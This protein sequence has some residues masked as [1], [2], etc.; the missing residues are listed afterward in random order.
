MD[1]IRGRLTAWYGTALPPVLAASV[2]VLSSPRR[3]ASF[4]DLDQRIASEADLTAGILTGVYRAGGAV[5]QRR[6]G[7]QPA[8]SQELA[9][10]LEAV[11]DFLIITTH[12]DSVLGASSDAQA[13]TFGEFDQ[14]R[15]LMG[16]AGPGRTTGTLR[17]TPNGPTLRYVV[18]LLHDAGP[19]VGALFAGADIA[20]AELG[21]QQLL[22]TLLLILVPRLALA[23]LV[24]S[25]ISRRALAPLDPIIEEVREISDGRSLHRR[26]PVPMEKDELGRL[27]VTLIQMMGRLDHSFAALQHFTADDRHELKTPLTVVRAGVERAITTPNLPRQT[28]EA[29]A[30]VLQEATR[31]AELVDALLTLARAD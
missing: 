5:V 13:L 11:P 12:E 28:L 23:V 21:A 15:R 20:S 3:T 10:T 6:A 2:I 26:L 9:A 19:Q 16:S 24:G 29:L 14:L 7:Q 17:I 8:L 1:T 22:S 30:E 31:M 27:A 25:F 4:K 18:L